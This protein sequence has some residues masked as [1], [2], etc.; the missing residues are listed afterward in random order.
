MVSKAEV[1]REVRLL[2]RPI[3]SLLGA[4]LAPV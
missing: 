4:A 1:V 2:F 3:S